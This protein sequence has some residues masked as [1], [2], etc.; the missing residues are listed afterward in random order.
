MILPCKLGLLPWVGKGDVMSLHHPQ[1]H[2]PGIQHE[3]G[4]KSRKFARF[5]DK[6]CRNVLIPMGT[7]AGSRELAS[8]LADFPWAHQAVAIGRIESAA[9]SNNEPSYTAMFVTPNRV[10][11]GPV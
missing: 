8:R 2:D 3:P 6:L 1:V 7:Y 9:H 11:I 5:S 10:W 4:A